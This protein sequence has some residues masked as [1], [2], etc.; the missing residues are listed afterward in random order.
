M[1]PSLPT[2]VW[3]SGYMWQKERTSSYKFSCGLYTIYTHWSMYTPTQEVNEGEKKPQNLRKVRHSSRCLWL[4]LGRQRQVGMYNWTAWSTQWGLGQS[5]L[6]SEILFQQNKRTWGKPG[7][8]IKMSSSKKKKFSLCSL[9]YMRI[10]WSG[11]SILPPSY[12]HKC[13]G[14]FFP[15]KKLM[16]F[17]CLHFLFF[18]QGL[19]V[20]YKKAWDLDFPALVSQV[21][22]L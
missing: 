11:S 16:Y 13:L 6:H 22:G 2:W 7:Y 14:F 18:Q 21:L 3:F 12:N 19:T 1:A 8:I 4:T 10:Q 15:F 5:G 17:S 20:L 9:T